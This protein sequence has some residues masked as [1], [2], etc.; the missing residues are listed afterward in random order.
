M[1]KIK[2]LGTIA[3]LILS[4]L[5]IAAQTDAEFEA[6]G[7]LVFTSLT[8]TVQE[9]PVEFVRIKTLHDLINDQPIS[10]KEKKIRHQQTEEEYDA[11]YLI[12]HKRQTLLKEQ[13]MRELLSGTRFELQAFEY[14]PEMTNIYTGTIRYLYEMSSVRALATMRFR[15]F[16][17]GKGFGLMGPVEVEY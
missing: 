10:D 7:Q 13:F 5:T 1:K 4:S 15:F 16:Y 3:L 14:E 6:F 9:K 8:D 12:F 17:N 2:S 11:N